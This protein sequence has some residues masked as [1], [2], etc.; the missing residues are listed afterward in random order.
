MRW[1]FLGLIRGYQ[2]TISRVVPSTCRFHPS[3]SVYTY[4]AIQRYGVVRGG[5]LGLRRIVRCHPLDPGGYD[6]VP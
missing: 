1:L 2:L 5:W 4:Q 3:C 6:P